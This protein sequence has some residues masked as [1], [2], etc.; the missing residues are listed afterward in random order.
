MRSIAIYLLDLESDA[1][2]CLEAD[3]YQKTACTWCAGCGH[4]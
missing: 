3:E 2:V 1:S 4:Y